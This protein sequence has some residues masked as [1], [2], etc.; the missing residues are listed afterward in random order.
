MKP[1]DWNGISYKLFSSNRDNITGGIIIANIIASFTIY[2]KLFNFYNNIL[3]FINSVRLFLN[4]SHKGYF[5]LQQV[6]INSTHYG[7]F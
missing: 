5:Y 6:Q 4:I 2:Y 3:Q 1:D 7:L